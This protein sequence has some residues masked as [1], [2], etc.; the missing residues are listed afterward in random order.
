VVSGLRGTNSGR[1]CHCCR[2]VGCGKE[3]IIVLVIKE[4]GKLKRGVGVRI[5]IMAIWKVARPAKKKMKISNNQHR[6]EGRRN[7]GTVGDG[8]YS[9]RQ[10]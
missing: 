1:Q 10:S 4:W 7:E 6:V 8:G 5:M 9:S 3:V 2:A